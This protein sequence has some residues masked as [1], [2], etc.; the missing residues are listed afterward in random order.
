MKVKLVGIDE[1]MHAELCKLFHKCKAIASL[2]L[3]KPVLSEK[4]QNVANDISNFLCS[5]LICDV[6]SRKAPDYTNIALYEQLKM[7]KKDVKKNPP[8]ST[9]R[10]YLCKRGKRNFR[11]PGKSVCRPG[12]FTKKLILFFKIYTYRERI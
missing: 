5:V 3:D 11:R 1:N 2:I 7:L 6:Y 4:E 12:R 9:R 10:R 8:A